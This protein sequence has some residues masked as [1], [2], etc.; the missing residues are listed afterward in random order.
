MLK[1]VSEEL[2]YGD[3]D[4][5]ISASLSNITVNRNSISGKKILLIIIL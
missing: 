5:E 2:I 4:L 1:A 3:S